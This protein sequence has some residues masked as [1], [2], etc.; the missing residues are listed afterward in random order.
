[1]LRKLI[2]AA[3]TAGP[4]VDCASACRRS[5]YER[6]AYAYPPKDP[7]PRLEFPVSTLLFSVGSCAIYTP[8][9]TAYM[10]AGMHMGMVRSLTVMSAPAM[11]EQRLT[12]GHHPSR[13]G[14]PSC[15]FSSLPACGLGALSTE[16]M[17]YVCHALARVQ[18]ALPYSV[19]ADGAMQRDMVARRAGT[20][21]ETDMIGKRRRMDAARKQHPPLS[22]RL[23]LLLY[24]TAQQ[25]LRSGTLAA[26]PLSAQTGQSNNGLAYVL[27]ASCPHIQ[28]SESS[29]KGFSSS[30]RHGCIS[31]LLP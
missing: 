5:G 22:G 24:T 15:C 14:S 9:N 19:C 11:V 20:M 26:A 8:I 30:W 21:A 4:S 10:F 12:T 29:N 6:E 23:H 31:S 2:C 28:G 18:S 7:Y 16:L 17:V 1:V 25:R 27:C 13:T 3:V